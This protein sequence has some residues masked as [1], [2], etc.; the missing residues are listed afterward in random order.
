VSTTPVPVKPAKPVSTTP[1]PAKQATT[2]TVTDKSKQVSTTTVPATNDDDDDD[3]L[4]SDSD[5]TEE[6]RTRI[7]E[8]RIKKAAKKGTKPATDLGFVFQPTPEG[9]RKQSKENLKQLQARA[10]EENMKAHNEASAKA[11]EIA[12]TGTK[13]EILKAMSEV[14]MIFERTPEE[15]VIQLLARA[16]EENMKAHNE[17]IAKA[18]EIAKTGT[19]EEIHKAMTEVTRIFDRTPEERVKQLKTQATYISDN[20]DGDE[21]A[22]S[23]EDDSDAEQVI[24]ISLIDR[25]IQSATKLD[26]A[27][28]SKS[29]D[30]TW[31]I[32]MENGDV[33]SGNLKKM[34]TA[35]NKVGVTDEIT[36]G[37]KEVK[38]FEKHELGQAYHISKSILTQALNITET[39]LNGMAKT[40]KW[41]NEIAV[42]L[43]MLDFPDV[44]KK[45]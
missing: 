14:T 4:D 22:E 21:T 38:K 36:L 42:K 6:Q 25:L 33:K 30:K 35:L 2:T 40:D 19:K 43:M 37:L 17:A 18:L 13:E 24:Q 32:V 23:S 34:K 3:N 20:D 39:E 12:K 31:V 26:K 28:Q 41:E 44:P 9:M 1:V 27:F 15:R 10:N 11:L 29:G 8:A 5:D 45:T 16:N 7:R